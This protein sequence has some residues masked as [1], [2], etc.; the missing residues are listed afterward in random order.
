MFSYN[1]S[2]HSTT[3]ST[4]FQLL[5]G[6]KPRLPAFPG[7]ELDRI[8]YGEHFVAERLQILKKA[9]QIAMDNSLLAGEKHKQAHDVKSKPH[10]IKEGDMVFVENQLFLGK[11]KKFSAKWVGPFLV[12]KVINEQNV[13]VQISPRRR[14]IHSVY[15]LKIFIDP[16]KSKYVDENEL[17]KHILT[18]DPDEEYAKLRQM[19]EQEDKLRKKKMEKELIKNSIEKR[20]TRSMTK[21][22]GTNEKMNQQQNA[23]FAI[24]N[25]IISDSEKLILWMIV[26]KIHQYLPLTQSEHT[27]WNS[28]EP[29]ERNFLLTGDEI[30]SPEIPRIP[31]NL[32][33]LTRNIEKVI[34]FQPAPQNNHPIPAHHPQPILEDIDWEETAADLE[35]EESLEL[36][37]SSDSEN[38]TTPPPIPSKK[39][40]RPTGSKNKPKPPQDDEDTIAKRTRSNPK[41]D[42]GPSCIQSSLFCNVSP[43]PGKWKPNTNSTAKQKHSPSGV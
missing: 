13:E 1:T 32:L 14:A 17:N 20:V 31:N 40:G 12:T 25:L 37:L 34:Q 7:P 30:F 21:N 29:K 4:P 16:E 18:P 11:N 3:K 15:R 28:F 35:T 43:H 33:K 19:S 2:Y 8:N 6:M 41:R 39:R 5:Y 38:P 10:N 27:Y 24:G 26:W 9:R 36:H 22:E 23:I 42:D